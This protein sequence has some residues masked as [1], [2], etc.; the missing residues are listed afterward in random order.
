M[1]AVQLE[2]RNSPFR[3]KELLGERRGCLYHMLTVIEDDEEL[4][5]TNEIEELQACIVRL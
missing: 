3:S 2:C 4:S 5:R 1:S